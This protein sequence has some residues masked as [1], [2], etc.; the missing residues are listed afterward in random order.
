[1]SNDNSNQPAIF[2]FNPDPANCV[3]MQVRVVTIDDE[4]WF[5][6]KDVCKVL[7]YKYVSQAVKD[8]C[9]PEGV[10]VR[11]APTSS[12]DQMMTHINEGNFYR[13]VIKSKKPEALQFEK[14]VCDT[15]LPSIR[16]HGGYTMGQ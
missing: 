2:H 15:V 3:T 14:W 12:G 6:A 4:P 13:L 11:L 9:R 8:N 7:G 1:M 5:V 10:S 16:K